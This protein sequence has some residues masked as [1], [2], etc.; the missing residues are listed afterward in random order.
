[1]DIR[2]IFFKFRSYTPIPIA[3]AIIYNSQPIL[4]FNVSGILLI[5]VGEVIRINAVKFNV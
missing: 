2:N 3:L 5:A 1:M 4:P